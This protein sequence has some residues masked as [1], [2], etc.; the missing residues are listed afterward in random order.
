MK[1]N[2]NLWQGTF[3]L[4]P[5]MTII[6]LT[7]KPALSSPLIPFFI[8]SEIRERDPVLSGAS[9]SFACFDKCENL[10]KY[11]TICKLVYL[12]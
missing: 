11:Y 1:L 2:I 6:M 8:G 7:L 10:G 5:K 12:V 9:V 3:F 4:I